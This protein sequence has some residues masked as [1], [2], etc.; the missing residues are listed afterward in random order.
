MLYRQPMLQLHKPFLA[1][2]AVGVL[3]AC[4]ADAPA[5]PASVAQ[6]IAVTCVE[7]GSPPPPTG[8]LLCGRE[9]T[10]ECGAVIPPLFVEASAPGWCASAR[11]TATPGGLALGAN[12][13]VVRDA[14]GDPASSVCTATV[15][16]VD[17]QPPVVTTRVVSLWPPNH[18][19]ETIRPADCLTVRDVCDEAPR[20]VF[21]WASVDEPDNTTGD[22]NTSED[23]RFVGCDAVAVR[24]ERRGNGDGRVYSLGVRVT[25]R[26]GNVTDEV[27]HVV[28]AHDQSGR[29]AVGTDPSR[30]I[31][32]GS[33]CP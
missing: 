13:V 1:C 30:H 8:A 20:A 11:L 19:M 18:R 7:P 33:T 5:P 22:G 15:V 9:Q 10:L 16:V 27:C 26:A 12:L 28:V 24:A 23:L 2:L 14:A 29:P 31:A 21:T 17:R 25:D 6:A 3:T 32:N 4:G